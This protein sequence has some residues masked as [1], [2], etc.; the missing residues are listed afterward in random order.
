MVPGC[1]ATPFN[2]R[3]A[4]FTPR[5]DLLAPAAKAMLFDRGTG[6]LRSALELP[7][8]DEDRSPS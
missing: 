3:V 4:D 2:K 6:L 8:V 1:G 5:A 7:L